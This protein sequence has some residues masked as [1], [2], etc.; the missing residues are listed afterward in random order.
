MNLSMRF[1]PFGQFEV[2]RSDIIRVEK[3]QGHAMV[4][5]EYPMVGL[6]WNCIVEVDT[7][8]SAAAS[9]MQVNAQQPNFSKNNRR[10]ANG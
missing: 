6:F 7:L 2:I 3:L 8:F 9:N 1:N 10:N 5:N 4:P